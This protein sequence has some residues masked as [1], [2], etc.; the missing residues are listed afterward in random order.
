MRD[1]PRVFDGSILAVLLAENRRR[2][3]ILDVN[4]P[5]LNAYLAG[6]NTQ[7]AECQ[8]SGVGR[9]V[10]PCCSLEFRRSRR[11]RERIKALRHHLENAGVLQVVPECLV[12]NGVERSG[13][14]TAA[15]GFEIGHSQPRPLLPHIEFDRDLALK[16]GS[17][18]SKTKH[19][20]GGQAC[21]TC[22]SNLEHEFPYFGG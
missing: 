3:R 1:E 16:G 19:H 21:K 18:R 11:V 17:R 2:S 14:G 13:L 22:L 12:K 10:A 9:R 6:I 5:A 8:Q 7:T 20:R 4:Q 15:A